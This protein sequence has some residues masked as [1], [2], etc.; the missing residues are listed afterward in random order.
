[1]NSDT[2]Y[3]ELLGVSPDASPEEIKRAYR[4]RARELHPDVNP[5][6]PEASER[7]KALNEAYEVL[8]DPEKRRI[9]D[10]Y[11]PDGLRAGAGAGSGFG[12]FT[13]FGDLFEAFFGTGMRTGPRTGPE[14]GDDLRFDLD[15]SLEEAATGV[16]RTIRLSRL[17]VCE[18]CRG[19]GAESGSRPETCPACR[20][21]GQVRQQQNTFLGSFATITT[22]GVCRGEGTV[23]RRPCGRC[24]GEGRYRSSEEVSVT[25][26]AGVDSGARL[27]L[28]G[29][30][31][32]G[33]RGGPAGDYYVVIHVRPHE[34]FKRAGDDL[35]TEVPVGIAQA[36]LGCRV[37]V[38]G[39]RGDVEL[40]I[41]PGVQPGDTFTIRGEGMPDLDGRGRGD[42]HVT[43][44]VMVPEDLT[45]EQRELLRK[46]AE[47]R[48]EETEMTRSF[49]ERLKEHLTGR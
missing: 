20:G 42:L 31:N 44:R 29:R 41:P 19:S 9:Y 37:S 48:G 40:E 33:R 7:F 11:G 36:A 1:M 3:Y 10:R 22:C 47:L 5:D 15:I 21:T 6:D 34:R 32:A 49:F 12:D 43:V 18:A 46:F 30:G 24:R 27:R 4:R 38:P 35:L 28:P 2:D 17:V 16:E 13:G 14:R 8:R 23:I 25:I 39:I 45:D 26:P